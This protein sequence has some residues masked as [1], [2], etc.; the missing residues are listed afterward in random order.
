MS[1]E[2]SD[3]GISFLGNKKKQPR[4]NIKQV[5]NRILSEIAKEGKVDYSN[6][7]TPIV[8]FS[9]DPKDFWTLGDA[10]KGVQIFGGIG[11]GKSS[12]SAKTLALNF[13]ARN[14]GGI[15]L[16]AKPD[17]ADTWIKYAEACGRKNDIIHFKEG[18]Q[19]YFNPLQYEM[20][21]TDEGG[22][23]TSNISN[24]FLNLYRMGQRIN[25]GGEAKGGEQFWESALK[26]CLNRVIDLIK[27]SGE[28]LSVSNMAKIVSSIP[29]AEDMVEIKKIKKDKD[30][31][32]HKNYCVKCVYL[33]DINKKQ[34][35]IKAKNNY[36]VIFN[37]F[38]T[39]LPR[40][41]PE[42]RT[43]IQEMFLGLAEPFL[44]GLLAD[45]FSEEFDGGEMLLPEETH[46][47]KI[48]L[49]DF[50]V[51][52][53][54]EAGIYS[55]L[56]Y[57]LIWQ[58]ATERRGD[59]EGHK[60]PVFLWVDESQYFLSEYDMLFQTTARSSVACTVFISQNISN[61]Y[62]V[63][64]GQN[65]KA[66]VDSLLGNLSTRI[67]HANVDFVTNEWAANSIGRVFKNMENINYSLTSM[68][69]SSSEQLHYQV[70]PIEF[71][72]LRMGGAPDFIVE[73][74]IMRNGNPWSDGN[75]FKKVNF[76]Q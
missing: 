73:G 14:F 74:I 33:A 29:T 35:D 23:L 65:P 66:R 41:H 5:A 13:I 20:S 62:A 11:S 57:K 71:N 50:S 72:T 27:M 48:I 12:G 75:N 22:G 34:E 56:I 53:Y 18:S 47:G 31:L 24:L 49:L 7:E 55:Q 32:N 8:K 1:L 26:R 69:G 16:C 2:F 15:V 51:K 6:L 54:L 38:F 36:L 21:R 67:F 40:L 61:Y 64:G 45:H 3:L 52:K 4:E 44:S 59:I 63:L 10:V 70:E 60:I 17:E 19:Y 46:K 68:S 39:E 25:G 37:Y 43:T 9:N 30:F 76:S 58:Q 28:V 42:T